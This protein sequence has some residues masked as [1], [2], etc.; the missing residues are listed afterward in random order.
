L[1]ASKERWNKLEHAQV[2][3]LHDQISML[4][5][6][7]HRVTL[8]TQWEHCLQVVPICH[9]QHS[10]YFPLHVF[11]QSNF[12]GWQLKVGNG[13]L[14]YPSFQQLQLVFKWTIRCTFGIRFPATNGI[15]LGSLASAAAFIPLDHW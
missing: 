3:V 12:N 5:S 2:T 14:G 1:E 7:L 13:N 4:S 9:P 11:I 10:Y 8:L 15:E 6:K